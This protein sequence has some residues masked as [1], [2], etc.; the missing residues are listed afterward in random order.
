ML[1]N[2]WTT[3]SITF[4]ET[5]DFTLMWQDPWKVSAFTDEI[6]LTNI[7]DGNLASP[8]RWAQFSVIYDNLD[9]ESSKARQFTIRPYRFFTCINAVGIMN[10]F[11]LFDFAWCPTKSGQWNWASNTCHSWPCTSGRRKVLCWHFLSRWL[12]RRYIY[13]WDCGYM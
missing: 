13:W 3:A 12:S 2:T 9:A 6:P 5:R 10:S 11:L 8:K 4:S 1:D 7:F